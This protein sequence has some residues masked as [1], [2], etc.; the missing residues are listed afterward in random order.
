M[1]HIKLFEDVAVQEKQEEGVY[2]NNIHYIKKSNDT[3]IS[4]KD[5]VKYILRPDKDENIEIFKEW[6]VAITNAGG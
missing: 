6:L 3:F 2:G 4:A 1:K 5:V